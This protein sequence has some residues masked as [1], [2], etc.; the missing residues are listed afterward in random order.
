MRRLIKWFLSLF[1]KKQPLSKAQQRVADDKAKEEKQKKRKNRLR[2]VSDPDKYSYVGSLRKCTR[3]VSEQRR[4]IRL[5]ERQGH[6]FYDIN[7]LYFLA[8]NRK[9]AKRKYNNYINQTSC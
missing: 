2:F 1:K 7:G 6:S 3:A 4:R 9:N 5:Q 8:L